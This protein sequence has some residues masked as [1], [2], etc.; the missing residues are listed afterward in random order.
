MEALPIFALMLGLGGL[1]LFLYLGTRR[2]GG[3]PN[4]PPRRKGRIKE[5]FWLSAEEF[6]AFVTD[7]CLEEPNNP[8]LFQVWVRSGT[9]EI[10][11]VSMRSGNEV[12][13][14]TVSLP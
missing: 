2:S 14:S 12:T 13:V 10:A 8:D 7:Q 11:A 1:A 4:V 6:E 5:S 9:R 3:I